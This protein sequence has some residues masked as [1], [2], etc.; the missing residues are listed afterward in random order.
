[1]CFT[2]AILC[3]CYR[4]VI[5]FCFPFKYWFVG[6]TTLKSVLFSC[7]MQY[8]I[9]TL[10]AHCVFLLFAFCLIITEHKPM[11]WFVFCVLCTMLGIVAGLPSWHKCVYYPQRT[12][13]RNYKASHFD[14]EL[15]TFYLNCTVRLWDHNQQ[16]WNLSKILHDRIFEPKI[17]H[18]KNAKIET[19]FANNKTA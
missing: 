11:H 18:T 5:I 12:K 3:F 2:K 16:T 4:L 15:N 13:D 14:P 19:S 17:L 9:L 10:P 8:G 1:M 7:I 6:G